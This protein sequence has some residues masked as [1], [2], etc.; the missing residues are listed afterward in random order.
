M[1]DVQLNGTTPSQA[2]CKEQQVLTTA[3]KTTPSF[4]FCE[5]ISFCKTPDADRI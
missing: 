1:I 4:S 3:S 5:Y 2:Y